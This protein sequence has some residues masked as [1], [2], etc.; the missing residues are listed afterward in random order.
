MRARSRRLDFGGYQVKSEYQPAL[1][2]LSEL[3]GYP[4]SLLGAILCGDLDIP[5]EGIAV[6]IRDRADLGLIVSALQRERDLIHYGALMVDSAVR[7]CKRAR[8]LGAESVEEGIELVSAWAE[9]KEMENEWRLY[10]GLLAHRIS[11]YDR[12]R[13]PELADLVD[14]N[15]VAYWFPREERKNG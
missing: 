5:A 6:R 1:D 13:S 8:A 7:I 15:W 11:Q 2:R 3:T 14:R 12:E 9:L 10:Q 4:S